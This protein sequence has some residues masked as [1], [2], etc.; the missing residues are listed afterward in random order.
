[1]H[2]ILYGLLSAV[3]AAGI[4]ILGKMGMSSV[5]PTLASAV[6]AAVMALFLTAVVGAT[7]KAALL[8][9]IDRRALLWIALTG[10]AGALSWLCYFLALQ[11]GPAVAV[12]ALDRTSVVFAV[13]FAALFLAES[14]DWRTLAGAG[15]VA[16]GAFLMA[17][18]R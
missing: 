8:G 15:L 1:M 12:V 16:A 14:A 10:V 2:W 9:T 6:R 13:A 3:F 17:M 5:D 4:P 18:P 11:T 7:G